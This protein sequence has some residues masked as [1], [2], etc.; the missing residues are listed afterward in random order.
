MKRIQRFP[1]IVE[2]IL[3]CLLVVGGVATAT[4][5]RAQRATASRGW[6]D[7]AVDPDL[8]RNV[9]LPGV[10]ADLTQYDAPTLDHALASIADAGFVWVRTT[11]AW[12]D[13]EPSEGQIDFS[14]YDPIVTAVAKYSKLRLVAVLNG[15]PA[16]A[17]RA[18]ASDRLTAP[19]ASMSAFGD[20]AGQVAARYSGKVDVYQVWDEPNLNTQW[21][22]LDPQAADYAA[23]LHAAYTAIH[24]HDANA[25]VIAAALA[26]TVETGPR[27][28]SDVLYLRE[29]YELHADDWFDAVAGK[30]Y[31]FDSSPTDRTVSQDTLN[32]SHIIL[33]RE[34][35]LRHGDGR[36][37]LWG[38][39]FGWNH[40]PDGW[41]GPPSIWGQVD[42]ATQRQYTL[43]AYSR[44]AREW[45][46]M[47]G[48][49]LEHWAPNAPAD[50]P[51]QGFAVSQ[52]AADWFNHGAFFAQPNDVVPSGFYDPTDPRFK[53]TGNWRFGPLGADV[54]YAQDTEAAADGSDHVLTF[55]FVGP[56]LA[57]SLRRANYVAYLYARVDGQPAN[58]LP[59]STSAPTDGY[60]YVLLKSP[61]LESHTDLI[62]IAQNLGPGVHS[63]EIRFYLG[64]EQWA[65]A[66]IGV[67]SPP[68]VGRSNLLFG[69]ALIVALLGLIGG[70]YSV[71]GIRL[72]VDRATLVPFAVY[73]RRMA[74]VLGGLAMS[75][76][77]ILG[78]V[79]T[80]NGVLPDI[81]RAETPTAALAILSAGLAYFHP[82]FIV[83]VVALLFLW[84]LIYNRPAVGLTLTLFWAP[85]FLA[86][87]QL[88]AWAAPFVEV[89]LLMTASAMLVR[90]LVHRTQG[91]I[92]VIRSFLA[93]LDWMD[94][95]IL[96][97]VI[98]ASVT[99]LWAEQR[100]PALR[101]WRIIILEPAL[102]YALLRIARLPKL[103][104][105]RMVDVLLLAAT[106]IVV[107]GL[108]G[109]FSPSSLGV[110]VAE[111]GTRRLASIYGSYASPNNLALFLGRCIP[112]ALAMALVAPGNARRIS[113]GIVT[114]LLAVA[115]VLTQSA[116]A[117]LLGVPAAVVVVLL[118]WNK[119]IGR[120]AVGVTVGGLAI[121]IPLA[122]FV[123]RLQGLIDLS[124]SSSFIRIQVWT[125][126]VNL[127]REHPFTGA[128][129]DQFLYLYRSRYILPDAWREPDLSHP[130]NFFLDYWISLGI[131]GLVV[132]AALQIT[133]WQTALAVWRRARNVDPI[134]AAL[135]VGAMGSMADFL[136]HG[137]VD[138]SYFLVDMAY[139]FCFTLAL[140]NRLKHLQ[141]EEE[142]S[143]ELEAAAVM[144]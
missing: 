4:G 98:V 8:P 50:D 135:A 9:P 15:S 79:L 42:A 20:F 28:L 104:W 110:V 38:S 113:A 143:H 53:Y 105:L 126:A 31:G 41:S 14:K 100:A 142:E 44:A 137:L 73:L 71:R 76:L 107:M 129:L 23:M 131:L 54:Q 11:F 80:W 111:Q 26:P 48:L 6:S 70:I 43:D 132:L 2:L 122:R 144:V 68:D 56:S 95:A 75:G 17:R 25:T 72:H 16:W 106:A 64:K 62:Q 18:D 35:M 138:N 119:V 87:V 140:V 112:F 96:L 27:N 19:P 55:Q 24:G 46:W 92:A 101:E 121:L 84:L 59:T 114:A 130:H 94:R 93:A 85:F 21:G 3:S 139:I 57:L 39:N 141:R 116:G 74:D 58:A 109:Y 33:L 40:L 66:G 52:V 22:G 60:G 134:I 1:L 34:E 127:L 61:D 136:A 63:A 124:R 30:P 97:L 133:F 86:P 78:M 81:V 125:S 67:G 29:L 117:L 128:G 99:L 115:V 10:N 13:I 123:P 91:P 83:T 108:I 69:G 5:V 49:I 7:P 118:L 65:L 89:S 82:A 77:A 120:I 103:D 36:K 90:G 32:F 88:Y 47:G 45:P 102:F 12:Q 37:A 51:I